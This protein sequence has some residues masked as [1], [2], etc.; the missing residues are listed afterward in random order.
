MILAHAQDTRA[1][2]EKA[3]AAID[4]RNYL[5]VVLGEM[6]AQQAR[7]GKYDLLFPLDTLDEHLTRIGALVLTGVERRDLYQYAQQKGYSVEECSPPFGGNIKRI[8]W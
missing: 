8:S 2:T 5:L 7:E 4:R 3:R 1:I 6:V